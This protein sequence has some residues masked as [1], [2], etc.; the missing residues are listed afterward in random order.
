MSERK[1]LVTPPSPGLSGH[2]REEMHG[3][4]RL[5]SSAMM[6]KLIKSLDLPIL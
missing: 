4:E 5:D 1:C 2:Q 3:K 6:T